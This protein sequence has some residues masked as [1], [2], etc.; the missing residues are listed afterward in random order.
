LALAYINKTIELPNVKTQNIE[1]IDLSDGSYTAGGNYRKDSLAVMRIWELECT[2]LTSSQYEAVENH[3]YGNNFGET[4]FWLDE[5]GGTS[6]A[7]S[8]TAFIF[9]QKDEREPFGKDGAWHD[10]GRNITLEVIEA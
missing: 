1:Y 5:F 2:H 10:G 8:I 9:I 3:L 6:S 4:D 7:D